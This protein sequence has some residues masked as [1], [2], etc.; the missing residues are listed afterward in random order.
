[1]SDKQEHQPVSGYQHQYGSIR[2]PADLIAIPGY[3][4]TVDFSKDSGRRLAEM[5]DRYEFSKA[6]EYPCG[7]KGCSTIHQ[8][9]YLVRT[10]DDKLTNIGQVCGKRHLDLD[11]TRVRKVYREKRKAADNRKA[12]T[13][14]RSNF[15]IHQARLDDVM[16]RSLA[17]SNCRATLRDC[18]P[19]QHDRVAEM[20]RKGRREIIRIRR[21]SKR[22]AQIHYSQTGTSR[23]D[24]EGGR[25]TVEEV[26]A[27]L[28]GIEFFK[29]S[30]G[31]LLKKQVLP[32]IR[33]LTEL[34]DDQVLAMAPRDLES[35]SRNAN[36]ALRLIA[37]A[38]EIAAHGMRFFSTDNI[39]QL[40]LMG[41]DPKLLERVIL[42]SE[43][44]QAFHAPQP[45]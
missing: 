34:R 43:E 12:I 25:P 31:I 24:Y 30:L 32:P 37:K 9:G 27:L 20:G 40:E 29:E 38:E 6:D 19:E 22:E 7:I 41:A 42:A 16:A 36:N 10:S 35:L 21:M 14:I 39:A 2:S 5:L 33:S 45:G 3:E 13:E 15:S 1:M 23:K 17:L 28:A 18:L 26:V 11:F 8:Y 44:L 4:A